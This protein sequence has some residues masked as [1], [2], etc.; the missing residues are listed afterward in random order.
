MKKKDV[1]LIA[2]LFIV[3][4]SV[5]IIKPIDDLD[6]VWNYNTA[7]VI[8]EGLIPYKDISMITTPLLPMITAIFLRVIANEVIVSR[9]LAA[10]IWSGILFTLYKVFRILVKEENTSLIFTALIAILCRN[11]FCIDYNVFV[12]FISLVILYNEL[13]NIDNIY[14]Y[15][16]RYDFII[17]IL[18]GLAICT[19]QSI[20]VTL[21]IIVVIYKGLFIENK[22]QFRQYIKIAY[23]RIVGILMPL[24]ILFIY[25]IFTGS[26]S[27]FIN[28][29][30]LGISEFSNKISYFELLQ[31]DKTEIKI[32]SVMVPVSILLMII[33]VFIRTIK[34]K[35]KDNILTTLITIMIYS[36]SIIIV[37]YPISDEIHFLIGSFISTIGLIY[38]LLLIG[39]KVYNKIKYKNKYKVYK[40][41]SL[42]AWLLVFSMILIVSIN[43]IYKYIK[44]DKNKDINHYKNIE[45][46]DY[47]KER[48]Y[49]IDNYILEK[50]KEGK[51]I[52]ILDSEACIYMIPINKYNKNYDMFLKGNIGRDGEN[53]QIRRI[54]EKD[55]NELYLIRNRNLSLNWQTPTNVIDYIKENLEFVEDVSI[56]EVYR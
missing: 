47:L 29:A 28:Y 51:K 21:A 3:V 24:T 30:I 49:D 26:F 1:L 48:I 45:V 18:A 42:I 7:R 4:F 14:I 20:G 11:I 54:K 50:E 41:I 46:Q 40:I 33:V 38:M 27:D 31:N 8:S 19:K 15:D 23:T 13:K 16:K 17:G 12:L 37:M 5:I 36:L 44:V 56:Y 32:L 34:N 43:N 9:V 25:L 53:S 52:Y 35:N 55:E 10:I 39:M 22:Q 2:F 6:E